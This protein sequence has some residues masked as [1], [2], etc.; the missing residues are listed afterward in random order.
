MG[1]TDTCLAGAPVP[2]GQRVET[3]DSRNPDS[4]NG[5]CVC[6]FEHPTADEKLFRLGNDLCCCWN[7][8][9]AKRHVQGDAQLA[10][11]SID[12]RLARDASCDALRGTEVVSRA[13]DAAGRVAR[14]PTLASAE[15]PFGKC[16]CSSWRVS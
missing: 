9:P 15:I 12:Q 7:R 3:D 14:A 1:H 13:L 11:G 10:A 16:R 4:G 5:L 8:G 6:L 2:E